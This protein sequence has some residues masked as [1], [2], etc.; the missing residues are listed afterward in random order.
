MKADPRPR[1]PA[2]ALKQNMGNTHP[3]TRPERLAPPKPGLRR[4]I[5]AV[6]ATHSGVA[7]TMP[8]SLPAW[9]E[10]WPE[11]RSGECWDD[12]GRG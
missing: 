3:V 11:E 1:T 5:V 2:P 10:G 12:G 7:A 4:V 8:V 6:H 9:P